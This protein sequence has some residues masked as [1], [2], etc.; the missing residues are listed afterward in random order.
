MQ[1]QK[2][3]TRAVYCHGLTFSKSCSNSNV[4]P[5]HPN[6]KLKQNVLHL[7]MCQRVKSF[8][9]D[10][11]H[12]ISKRHYK[13]NLISC[14]YKSKSKREMFTCAYICLGASVMIFEVANFTLY[15]VDLC[16]EKLFLH[17]IYLEMVIFRIY[18]SCYATMVQSEFSV[19]WLLVIV[20][21]FLPCCYFH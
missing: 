3:L 7:V 5:R 13:V 14:N 17:F 12:V 21:R 8:V 6:L 16:I 1:S 4:K 9:P 19:V 10:S 2:S 11:H 18:S 15:Q 20:S